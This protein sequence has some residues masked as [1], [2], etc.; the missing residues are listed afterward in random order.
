[1]DDLFHDAE[2]GQ[3]AR[4]KV[5]THHLDELAL[6][7]FQGANGIASYFLTKASAQSGV[8]FALKSQWQT[9]TQCFVVRKTYT[10][11]AGDLAKSVRVHAE[12]PVSQYFADCRGL[13]DHPAVQLGGPPETAVFPTDIF[14]V[15]V[16]LEGT[17]VFAW[18]VSQRHVDP[19]IP[20]RQT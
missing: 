8:L 19:K 17:P 1:M 10:E 5:Q 3:L 11:P 14:P 18:T 6:K 4:V 7:H 13:R 15:G 2:P 16:A 9:V 12:V 20:D